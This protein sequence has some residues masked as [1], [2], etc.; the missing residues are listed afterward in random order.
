[1]PLLHALLAE[2]ESVALEEQLAS[3]IFRFP[4]VSIGWQRLEDGPATFDGPVA[5]V[6]LALPLFDRNRSQR[7]EMEGRRRALEA[8]I[9]Q[10]E[11]E[12]ASSWQAALEVYELLRAQASAAAGVSGD[13]DSVVTGAAA[14]FRLGESDLAD[15]LEALRAARDAELDALE[16]HA[17]ALEALRQL[18]GLYGA[19]TTADASLSPTTAAAAGT[20]DEKE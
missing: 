15:F 6:E 2:L 11:R 9:A 3:R 12:M 8:R 17:A 14:G 5:G 4:E 10:R 1:D 16:L 18:D 20:R 7:L 19:A 13:A